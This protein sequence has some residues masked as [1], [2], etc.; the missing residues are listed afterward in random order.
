MKRIVAFLLALT[1]TLTMTTLTWAEGESVGA[2]GPTSG[3]CGAES[4]V[5]GR[6]SVTWEVTPNGGKVASEDEDG[7]TVLLPAY[8]LTIS[9]KGEMMD[10]PGTTNTVDSKGNL[11]Q[12]AENWNTMD[13]GM[14]GSQVTQVIVEEGVTGIGAVAFNR[15]L[16]K[17][18]ISIPASVTKIGKRALGAEM[19][20][21]LAEGNT[22]FKMVDNVL[23]TSDMKTLVRYFPGE[24]TVDSYT[25]PASVE[26]ILGGAF[27]KAKI[28]H[29]DL[30]SVKFIGEYAF[31]QAE[32]PEIVLPESVTEIEPQLVNGAKVQKLVLNMN[33]AEMP[34]NWLY[35]AAVEEVVIGK[36]IT[37]LDN[38]FKN[39]NIKKVTFAADSNVKEFVGGTFWGMKYLE[40]IVIPNSVEKMGEAAFR[41]CTN[42]KSVVIGSDIKVIPKDAFLQCS[43]LESV[44]FAE[45]SQLTSIG[46]KDAPTV[47]A[48]ANTAL[49]SIELP[50]SC[51]YVGINTF[52]DCPS[53]RTI[54]ARGVKE[55]GDFKCNYNDSSGFYKATVSYG[56]VLRGTYKPSHN[57]IGMAQYDVNGVPTTTLGWYT[58]NGVKGD[59][60][61]INGTSTTVYAVYKADCSFD[62]NG[63]TGDVAAIKSYVAP[64]LD[65]GAEITNL[66]QDEVT[67]PA[68]KPTRDGYTFLNWNTAADGSGDSYQPIEYLKTTN[69]PLTKLYAQWG[70]RAE[71]GTIYTVS[72]DTSLVYTG[73]EQTPNVTVKMT[74]GNTTTTLTAGT[75]RV[76]ADTD[77]SAVLHKGTVYLVENDVD[78]GV[79]IDFN[80]EIKKAPCAL[81]VDRDSVSVKGKGTV[82]LHVSGTDV[83]LTTDGD[84]KGSLGENGVYTAVA[85]DSTKNYT[86]TFTDAGNKN[87]EGGTKSVTVYVTARSSA[88]L[89]LSETTKTVKAGAADSVSYT[90]NGDGAVTAAS[91]DETVAK[92]TVD[93]AKKTISITPLKQGAADIL[94]TGAATENYKETAAVLVLT[95]EQRDVSLT[96]SAADKTVKAGV[97]DSVTY[98]YD[99]DGTVTAASSDETVAKV[100]VDEAKTTISITPLK[101]GK[102]DITV[103]AAATDS[104][105]A[106]SA[107]LKLTVTTAAVI[108]SGEATMEIDAGP[109]KE[110]RV[111]V[112]EING[113]PATVVF[114]KAAADYLRGLGKDLTLS[115]KTVTVPD[116]LKNSEQAKGKTC[117][118]VEITLTDVN[119]QNAF[120]TGLPAGAQATVEFYGADG[121]ENVKAYFVNANGGLEAL[122]E[123]Q[124]EYASNGLIMLTLEHF[125]QYL[126]AGEEPVTPP[127]PTPTP[128]RPIRINQTKTTSPGTGDA[129]VAIYAVSAMLSMAGGVC[130]FRKKKDD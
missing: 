39:S 121:M 20:V 57:G 4:N 104:C 106:A 31:Q 7:N 36:H 30:G 116:S 61:T 111:S 102:A 51:T 83:T 82:T 16:H 93:E 126:V 24:G 18:T 97:A 50:D 60:N 15:N 34:T 73:E 117:V 70:K 17:S 113:K 129:G 114:N 124:Y 10:E 47:K 107:T 13:G 81:T 46:I 112:P 77:F 78:T 63:G 1:M 89:T 103:T 48:F 115:L 120:G 62:L 42:L 110:L 37:K 122:D 38:T 91:S 21:T 28:N 123:Q 71:D 109:A 88:N 67:I 105:K 96:L 119:G 40:S 44:T 127:T 43:S 12:G 125:S 99:G 94:V 130:L 108:K 101:E 8:T 35:G 65:D 45:G 6:G 56:A 19:V 59:K 68:T 76:E 85:P 66:P 75:Y 54:V 58:Q 74:K 64:G 100:T 69:Q 84:L 5:G 90:Y 14:Y 98:T 3:T 72:C 11:K 27:Q 9:G 26:T 22:S 2:T 23:F 55:Q 118:M 128:S 80:Y 95:V 25:V 92:V 79:T 29:F 49:E 86:V 87:Y 33:M 53:L 41:G 32:I 52:A